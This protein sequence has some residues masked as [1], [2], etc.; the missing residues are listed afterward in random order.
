MTL[1]APGPAPC[2]SDL[3]ERCM[4]QGAEHAQARRYVEADASFCDAIRHK[5]DFAAAYNNLGWVRQMLGDAEGAQ[6]R[7]RQCLDLD[8]SLRA[9]R[10]NLL[11]L[12]VEA[13]LREESFDVWYD[14][15]TGGADA[16]VFLEE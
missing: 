8:P 14:A 11:M 16:L 5:Q 15:A 3:A 9:A 1:L 2:S 12:L 7:Y 13:G 10:R 4:A 6:L